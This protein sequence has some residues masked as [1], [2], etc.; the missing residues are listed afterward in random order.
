M[1]LHKLLP[2]FLFPWIGSCG[3]GL[4]PK[5]PSYK[6][7]LKFESVD[8]EPTTLDGKYLSKPLQLCKSLDGMPSDPAEIGLIMDRTDFNPTAFTA[9]VI[10]SDQASGQSRVKDISIHMRDID[11][12]GA[13]GNTDLSDG[14]ALLNQGKTF[15]K[16]AIA[17][18]LKGY[19]VVKV[20]D[21]ALCQFWKI[22]G[23]S[24]LGDGLAAR[25]WANTKGFFPKS[26]RK[27]YKD[28]QGQLKPYFSPWPINSLQ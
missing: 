27:T 23:R 25:T 9:T 16:F 21:K 15:V 13:P 22:S 2:I 12:S 10:K 1:N 19:M 18:F 8:T 24:N 3:H 26:W 6:L 11:A 5:P 4:K 7:A 17:D 14:V 20:G 28:F